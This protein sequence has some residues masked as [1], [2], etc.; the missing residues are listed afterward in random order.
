MVQEAEKRWPGTA[1]SRILDV[2]EDEDVF[3]VGTIFKEMGLKP[4]ILDEYTKDRGV[5]QQLGGTNFTQ[6]SDVAILEDEGGRVTLAGAKVD[7]GMLVTGVIAAMRGKALASGEFQVTDVCFA[8]MAPQAVP[9]PDD[10]KPENGDAYVALTSG[11]ALGDE[12]TDYL[13]LQMMLDYCSGLVGCEAEQKLASQIVRVVI[14][15][16]ILKGN[17]ALSQPTSYATVREQATALMPVRDADVL[18]TDLAATVDVDIMPGVA[19]PANYSLPQQPL[20]HC[21]LPTAASISTFVRATNPHSFEIDGVS[22]L[23]TSGQ[24]VE[25][26]A[27][28]SN[29][30]GAAAIQEHMLSWRH[31]IPTA[32]DSLAAYPYS[33][34]DPFIL[35]SSPHILFAGGQPS[36]ASSLV[37]GPTGQRTQVISVPDF[38]SSPVLVLVNLRT[39]DVQP[40]YFDTHINI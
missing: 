27:R 2:K 35:E 31:I 12:S 22:F 13:K 1:H 38:S 32:P 36:F 11:L 9:K 23:G 29:L 8:G 37:K 5:G 17:A 21:L 19:D 30:E 16:G 24:N 4:S 20:H 6:A 39:L 25:D 10:P 15:G 26:V 34:E 28:Y 33:G 40:I 7:A 14:A 3:I 18:L